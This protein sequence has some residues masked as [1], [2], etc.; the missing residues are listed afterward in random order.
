MIQQC[1]KCQSYYNDETVE[2]CPLC[3]IEMEEKSKNYTKANNEIG[4]AKDRCC[5]CDSLINPKDYEEK[6]NYCSK[7]STL[8]SEMATIRTKSEIFVKKLCR[9]KKCWQGY[10]AKKN[11]KGNIA[12]T[13][14]KKCKF[15]DLTKIEK[16]QLFT[17]L[18]HNSGRGD[19]IIRD[20]SEINVDLCLK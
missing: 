13:K 4:I 6:G 8:A 14:C 9:N 16:H 19:L 20:A 5:S 7:C 3:L 11:K 12:R 10:I 18:F 2:S 17:E 15:R 1:K